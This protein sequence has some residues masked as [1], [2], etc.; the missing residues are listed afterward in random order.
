MAE[1]LGDGPDVGAGRDEQR[2]ACVPQGVRLLCFCGQRKRGE[3]SGGERQGMEDFGASGIASERMAADL[4]PDERLVFMNA[5]ECS[6][7]WTVPWDL[8]GIFGEAPEAQLIERTRAALRK[9]L[10]LGWVEIYWYDSG[11]HSGGRPI[12]AE[13]Y[14]RVLGDEG[15]W[16]GQQPGVELVTTETGQEV[17]LHAPWLDDMLHLMLCGPGPEHWREKRERLLREERHK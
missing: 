9:L 7:L 4:T 15:T 11:R 12:S 5:Q 17:L 3:S 6:G 8:R 2:G 1:A 14:E 16:D 10:G 13:E